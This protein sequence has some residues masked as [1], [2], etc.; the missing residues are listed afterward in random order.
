MAPA[1]LLAL[2]LAFGRYIGEDQLE[3][4]RDSLRVPPPRRRA[5]R[6]GQPPR[7]LRVLMPRGGALI[8]AD[9]ASRPPP[10]LLQLT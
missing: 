9:L 10:H 1:L 5:V 7:S 3:R 8:A 6:T 2:P 4:C